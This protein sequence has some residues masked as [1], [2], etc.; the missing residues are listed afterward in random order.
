MSRWLKSVNNLLDKLDDHAENADVQNVA[1]VVTQRMLLGRKKHH[2]D[3][4]DS[5]VERD[6]G[7]DD[8]YNESDDDEYVD[9]DGADENNEVISMEDIG[10]EENTANSMDDKNRESSD[11]QHGSLQQ[12]LAKQVNNLPLNLSA[13]SEDTSPGA[14]E[15]DPPNLL[16]N[17]AALVAPPTSTG[18]RTNSR[19]AKKLQPDYQ[20]IL[21]QN[22]KLQ[23]ELDH[24]RVELLAQQDELQA[25]AR[26]M[27][28]DRD[29]AAEEREELLEE[30]DEELQ[31]LKETYEKQLGEQREM[32]ESMLDEM[33]E[34]LEGEEQKRLQ[35]GGDW[36]KEL[37]D[38]LKR[39]RQLQREIGQELT[40]KQKLASLVTQLTTNN[41]TLQKKLISLSTAFREA[42]DKERLA[43]AKLDIMVVQHQ[44]QLQQR[45][46]REVELEKT[47][48]DLGTA[49]T[50]SEQQLRRHKD[51]SPAS[52]S[53]SSWKEKYEARND[54]LGQA[55]AQIAL[56]TQQYQSMEIELKEMSHERACEAALA[57]E[58]QREF[59]QK[60]SNLNA[61]ILRLETLLREAKYGQDESEGCDSSSTIPASSRIQQLS[62]ELDKTKRQL[63]SVS[64]QLIDQTNVAHNAKSEALTLKGRL[65]SAILRAEAAENALASNQLGVV[66]EAPL[67]TM[68]Y[69]VTSRG[70]RRRI[71]G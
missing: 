18:S 16:P 41:E 48:M 36:T 33:R 47:I 12:D 6:N 63:V 3:D 53:G 22:V 55:K 5:D 62:T 29:K 35:E 66:F 38:S 28:S 61:T 57:Q 56:M 65:E 14:T 50:F 20:N 1:A 54:D 26:R 32:Y 23:K 8:D 11:V 4:S 71:R 59:D 30:Q 15:P 68:D 39:E 27:Q 2:G 51:T 40:E 10:E 13:F 45:Q 49:L 43:E 7:D 37:E 31:Q 58:K 52:P 69:M 25:A 60:I 17:Q 24:L 19:R 64:E 70:R 9:E 42:S 34:R 21:Q 67:G 44:R 46:E